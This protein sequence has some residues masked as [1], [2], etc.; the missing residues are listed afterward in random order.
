M[1]DN[2]NTIILANSAIWQDWVE[3]L[4]TQAD[5]YGLW[6]HTKGNKPLL[7]IPV[8]P[9]LTDFP[10]K[11]NTP[12]QEVIG[13]I[14]PT[15]S[16]QSTIAT[17]TP[18]TGITAG[19]PTHITY[20]NM[21]AEGQKA[22]NATWSHYQDEAKSFKEQEDN[23]RKLKQWILANVSAH[24]QKTCCKGGQ[25]LH[26]WF[27]NLKKAAGISKRLEDNMA[28]NKYKEA[29]KTPKIKD[30]TTWADN[31][32]QVMTDSKRKEVLAT[33]RA[34]EWFEDVITALKEM[35][36]SWIQAY[37]INKNSEIENNTLDYR[38]VANDIRQAASQYTANK[39][40]R[41]AKS[42]F[43]PTFA[44]EGSDDPEKDTEKKSSGKRKRT[45]SNRQSF[46]FPKRRRHNNN[47]DNDMD[48]VC[49]GFEGF[50]PTYKCFYI[51]P[52]K[53]PKTWKPQPYLKRAVEEAIRKDPSLESGPAPKKGKKV[54]EED[55]Q[56]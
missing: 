26:Q 40:S 10:L 46:Q 12:T 3:S 32:E 45:D 27:E 54:K 24:Y 8:K 51:H 52:D 29:V 53:A 41:V 42:S 23:I 36:P 6:D 55:K 33:T 11:Q 14:N 21:T 48:K 30:L 5:M 35:F 38:T 56:D 7:P 31:W 25:S 47:D 49:R 44:G 18:A 4:E 22:Y 1:S 2:K 19:I 13:E 50:H 37:A 28:R 20:L 34:P 39:P 43:G 9:R 17:A 16:G 15:S